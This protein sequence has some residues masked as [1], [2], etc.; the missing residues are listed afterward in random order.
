MGLIFLLSYPL[1]Y[2]LAEYKFQQTLGKMLTKSIVINE[3]A[4]APSLSTCLLRTLIRFVPFEGFSC[5]GSPSRGW[6][7][8]WTKTYVVHKDEVPKLKALLIKYNPVNNTI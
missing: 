1:Y 6:H 4:E 3:F 7:D 5:L 2:M 8:R